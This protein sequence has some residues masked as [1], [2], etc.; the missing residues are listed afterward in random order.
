MNRTSTD[1][2]GRRIMQVHWT[3]PPT[4]GGVESHIADLARMLTEEGLKITV[5]TGEE[6]PTAYPGIDIIVTPMLNLKNLRGEEFHRA[7]VCAFA[8]FLDDIVTRKHIDV[9]HGHNLHH[10][11]PVPALAL[12]KIR[13]DRNIQ[14][15]QSFHETWPDLLSER[16]VY[17]VWH[18]NYAPSRFVLRQCEELL[19]FTPEFF[20]LGIDVSLFA[21][22]TAPF[23]TTSTPVILHPARLLPW[24]GAHVTV[25]ML[26]KLHNQRLAA[27]LVL[28]DTQRIADWNHEWESYRADILALIT[29]LGL[30]KSVRFCSASYADMP[31]LYAAA[32]VVV[33]PTVGE[34]PYG[35]VPLE[36]M[37][38]ARPVVASRSGGIVETVV[39]GST[40]YIVARDDA[41]ALA[42]RV[43]RL[44]RDPALARRFGRAG[45]RHVERH[46]DARQ[47][48]ARLI[49]R[50][51]TGVMRPAPP[52]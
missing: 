49:E 7:D 39:D 36:A 14:I 51:T 6:Y 34:E 16:P 45:R 19:G 8:T 38:C 23:E 11:S 13:Q 4:T 24:K 31:R 15:H 17:R 26:R 25:Q 44:L 52:A 43:G 47:Y 50:Y 3:F 32:D 2:V 1:H 20:P 30:E 37:S 12:D 46:F 9:I 22:R 5:L 29:S 27:E 10:F 28:T 48:V 21:C 18:G 40:G 41:D 33:Y 35:L 42:D